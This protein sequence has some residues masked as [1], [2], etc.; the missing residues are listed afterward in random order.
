MHGKD[1]IKQK[2]NK[3]TN[4]KERKKEREKKK[5]RKKER[6]TYGKKNKSIINYNV[7]ET[8]E[9]E[10]EKKAFYALS[11]SFPSLKYKNSLF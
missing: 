1:T 11:S 10:K 3:Q 9:E 6:D 7:K 2:I 5:E 4:K 8:N